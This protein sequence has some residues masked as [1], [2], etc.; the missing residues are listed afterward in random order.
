MGEKIKKLSVQHL[1][2]CDKLDNGCNGGLPMNAFSWLH[3][4]KLVLEAKY[5]YTAKY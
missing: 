5:P 1:L 2:D 3:D 4:N